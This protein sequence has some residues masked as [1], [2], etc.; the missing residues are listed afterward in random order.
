MTY[1]GKKLIKDIW[2]EL[3]SWFWLRKMIKDLYNNQ[4]AKK[5]RKHSY[6]KKRR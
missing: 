1:R 5:N 6:Q 2:K 3:K 4:N